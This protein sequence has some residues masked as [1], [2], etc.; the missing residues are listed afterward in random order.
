MNPVPPPVPPVRPAPSGLCIASLVLGILGLCNGVTGIPA[1]I[2]GHIGLSKV[3]RSGGAVGGRGMGIAGLVMGYLSTIG[4]LAFVAMVTTAGNAARKQQAKAG[5][6]F[7]LAAVPVPAMPATPVFTPLGEKGVRYAAVEIAAGDG[8][9]ERMWMRVYL[10]P[11]ERAP[12]T[13][14]AV[15]VAP[16]G[17]NLLS[18]S[19]LGPPTE[20]DYHDECLP[21]AEEG[22][23]VVFYSIDGEV[24]DEEDEDSIAEG[25]K[26]FRDACGGLVN[27][28][29]ALEFVLASL[30]EVDPV[31]IY[32]AGH[33]SAGT[34]S[35]LFGE[36]EPRLAGSIAYA[37]AADVEKHLAEVLETPMI[38]V[39]LPGVKHFA[40]RSS[41]ATH[42]ARLCQP[43]FLFH[44]E[45][46]DTVPIEDTREFARKAKAAGVRVTF[47]VAGEGG[48]Y[49]PMI[50]EGIPAA[51][52]WI[53]G[54]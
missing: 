6:R 39:A 48:H 37:P 42:V 45:D 33:S 27:G 9:G 10:P 21:Y 16:A 43:L 23:A 20:E 49:L 17:T 26:K 25:Y 13:L 32:S 3:K 15:L 12:G 31:R 18:G 53:K 47:E 14:P 24:A 41:P 36:H 40:K 4:L 22:I 8:P 7:D 11:D 28:R 2:C 35:L 1:V 54:Y 34:L 29:N 46:D 51:I 30:P 5:E 44:A 38:G 50:E 52:Q 19:D